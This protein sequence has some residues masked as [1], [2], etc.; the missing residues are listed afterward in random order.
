[1]KS[2][3]GFT[4]IELWVVIAIIGILAAILLP[5]LARAREAARRASCQNNLKQ[6]GIIF[7]MYASEAKGEFLPRIQGPDPFVLV[8]LTEGTL[9]TDCGANDDD[10][11]MF[12][13]SDVYPDYLTDWNV[14]ECP[15]DPNADVDVINPGCLYAGLAS[16]PDTSYVYMGY[17]LD[18]CDGTDA[19]TSAPDV[20]NGAANI[21]S[22][23]LGVFFTLAGENVLSGPRPMTPAQGAQVVKAA[24]NDLDIEGVAPNAGNSQ[25]NT[26]H[27]LK[28]GIERFLLTDINDTARTAAAQSTVVTMFDL[29]NINPNGSGE[30]NH[31]PGGGNALYLDGHVQFLKYDP[32]G[33][34][35]INKA[36]GTAVLWAAGD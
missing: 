7:K 8:G 22:Q 25:T 4:L 16:N 18:G 6:M 11:F 3:R 10:D 36:F 19:T 9:G 30:Y 32:T 33:P 31:V 29:I 35:P 2:K 14:I 12:N 27:R 13:V 34:F 24:K 28:E 26:V 17:L 15:S 23:L 5:A 1:M 21:S 20:G